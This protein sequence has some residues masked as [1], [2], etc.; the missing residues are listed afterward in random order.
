MTYLYVNFYSKNSINDTHEKVA[1]YTEKVL[2]VLKNLIG[3]CES[4]RNCY[5]SYKILSSVVMKLKF[6]QFGED[7]A[8]FSGANT[9]TAQTK[10]TFNHSPYIKKAKTLDFDGDTFDHKGLEKTAIEDRPSLD[11]P[12]EEF[13]TVLEK[14][15]ISQTDAPDVNENNSTINDG[16]PL[17]IPPAVNNQMNSNNQDIMDIL[18]QVT[19]GSVWDEFFVKSGNANEDDYDFN[20]GS[21]AGSNGLI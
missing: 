18:F 17:N 14:Y 3:F 11:I 16:D 10:G 21:N 19:S 13:F 2:T 9:L 6:M 7:N 4:A 8:T 5:T 20:K 12:L 1:E 15:N